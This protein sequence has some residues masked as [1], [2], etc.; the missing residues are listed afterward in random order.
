M[1]N[2]L[3]LI[4]LFLFFNQ[5]FAQIES[6]LFLEKAYIT[7]IK[8]FKDNIFVATYGQGIYQY[9]IKEGI[10][11]NFSS[12]SGNLDNDLFH[13][14]AASDDFIW[15]GSNDGLYIYTKRNRK[16]TVKK[17]SEGGQ[18]GNWIRALHY[19]YK[20]NIL[21]IGR[22]QNITLYDV[23]SNSY[24]EFSRVINNNEKTNNINC[25]SS[26]GD[27]V[28][29]F[30]AEFG[31][32]KLVLDSKNEFNQWSYFNNKGREFLGQGDMVSVSDIL[33]LKKYL[34]FA[35][36]EFKTKENP[37]YNIGGLYL[38]D[39][40]FNWKRIE[41]S[42]GLQANGIFSLVRIGNYILAS[43]YEFNPTKKI[44]VGKGLAI[45]NLSNHKV[46]PIDLNQFEI[47]SSEIRVTYFDGKFLWLGTSSG[48]VRI[49]FFNNLAKWGL[50]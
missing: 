28:L 50:R 17:F 37:N 34:W 45:I 41:K 40:R 8:Q 24:R 4:S 7:D 3:K 20:R 31:V 39:R 10:W 29:W 11:R 12:K 13:C 46:S 18:F 1:K 9:L 23:K 47:K 16:W 42:D 49:N 26:D 48:L 14:V 35:T 43:V 44:E 33:P 38:N 21:W 22:F 36:D 30:G 15:A 5:S 2:I 32:H 27:S 6:K 19:D 25:I